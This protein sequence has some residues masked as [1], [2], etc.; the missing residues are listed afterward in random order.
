M[1]E[2]EESNPSLV[3]PQP[4]VMCSIC[5]SCSSTDTYLTHRRP[6]ARHSNVWLNQVLPNRRAALPTRHIAICW[7]GFLNQGRAVRLASVLTRGNR[8]S[9]GEER[10]KKMGLPLLATGSCRTELCD[11]I[12]SDK[13]EVTPCL[14]SNSLFFSLLLPLTSLLF[15]L[16]F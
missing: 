3:S 14:T 15:L 9:T 1:A 12:T 13:T 10:W 6:S 8:R 11:P 2:G 7:F 4:P 5:F 16:S